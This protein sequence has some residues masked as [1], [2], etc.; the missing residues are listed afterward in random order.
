MK[1]DEMLKSP[2]LLII[3][4]RKKNA[5]R[6]LESIRKYAPYRLYIAADGPR[7]D[8][9][10]ELEKCISTREDILNAIDWECEVFTKFE[11]SNLGCDN[12]VP[13]AISW[14]FNKEDA[15][16]ILEDDCLPASDFFNYCHELL[17]L[18]KN[19]ERIMHISGTNFMRGNTI[20][21]AS[22]FWSKQPLIW[23]W[24]TW[25]R[26]W[27]K[28]D[29]TM[30]NYQEFKSN[31]LISSVSSDF[32]FKK[33]RIFHFDKIS[34][35]NQKSY[36]KLAWDFTWS[37]CVY[38]NNGLCAT[39]NENLISNIGFD[40]SATHARLANDPDSNIPLGVLKT[41][42]HPS[43]FLPDCNADRYIWKNHHMYSVK[44]IAWKFYYKTVLLFSNLFRSLHN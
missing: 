20:G 2:V 9:S 34:K 25:K 12:A 32:I 26:A 28:F 42:S 1:V 18:Y 29:I 35:N 11:K 15:G 31:E 10:G 8:R 4:N 3:F 43:I 17:N 38:I 19:D 27:L 30:S 23:G 21:N 6:V 22:Y 39:P 37:F 44:G 36:R 33:L 7:D 14:F 40:E 13:D 5:L 24:A 16:I 41:L